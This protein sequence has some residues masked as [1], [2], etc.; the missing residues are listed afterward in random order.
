MK[1]DQRVKDLEILRTN[2]L[3]SF[4]FEHRR[5]TYIVDQLL[6]Q[7]ITWENNMGKLDH[8]PFTKIVHEFTEYAD[9]LYDD[10]IF[11]L[12]DEEWSKKII[13]N[14]ASKRFNHMLNYCNFRNRN[15]YKGKD[16]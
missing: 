5:E 3:K 1:C 11:K 2:S 7:N 8:T 10:R 14:I 16:I 6:V 15:K 13:T 12:Y 4:K 9:R